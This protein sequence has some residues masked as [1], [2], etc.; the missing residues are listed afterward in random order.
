MRT[1]LSCLAAAAALMSG[2]ASAD[3]LPS[4]TFDTF[5]LQYVSDT[6]S[7]SGGAPAFSVLSSSA[8]QTQL[9]LD[10]MASLLQAADHGGSA[11]TFSDALVLGLQAGA[12]YRITGY[13]LS[14]T[15]SG[16]LEVGAAP[17]GA[18]VTTAGSAQNSVTFDM[19]LWA[20]GAQVTD[21]GRLWHQVQLNAD[22][23][24]DFHE[25]NWQGREAFELRL[26][27]S[28]M[29]GAQATAWSDPSCSACTTASFAQMNVLNPVLTVY[30]EAVA[31]PEPATWA[32][33]AGG[34]T[35]VGGAVRRRRRA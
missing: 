7:P 27:T 22:Q 26:T 4:A 10:S 5:A 24:F 2:A 12:G 32:M 11:Q 31:V 16:D 3:T 15:L 21:G 20:P 13:S 18:T 33:L 14:G 25:Q 1:T 29:A 19:Q 23:P 9:S 17:A 8:T 34:L 6:M 35:L 28:V 30:T